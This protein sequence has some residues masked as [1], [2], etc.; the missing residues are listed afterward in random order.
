MLGEEV[1]VGCD[2]VLVVRGR[3]LLR[4]VPFPL[5]IFIILGH[6][7]LGCKECNIPNLIAIVVQRT[8]KVP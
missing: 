2:G 3:L 4:G 5:V 7:S 8:S 6:P 1:R